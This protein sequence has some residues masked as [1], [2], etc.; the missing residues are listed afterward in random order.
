MLLHSAAIFVQGNKITSLL[1][2]YNRTTYIRFAIMEPKTMFWYF[3]RFMPELQQDGI[4]F[5]VCLMYVNILLNVA[6]VRKYCS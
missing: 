6:L 3:I 5:H 1:L 2:R 4:R